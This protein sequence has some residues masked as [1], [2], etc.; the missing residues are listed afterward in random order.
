MYAQNRFHRIFH[1][2]KENFN[3]L[4]AHHLKI[5]QQIQLYIYHQHHSRS[6]KTLEG[7]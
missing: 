5:A 6:R 7:R 3:K 2:I 4:I 1:Y